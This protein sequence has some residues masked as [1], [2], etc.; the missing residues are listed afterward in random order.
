MNSPPGIHVQGS[1]EDDW[2]MF[3]ELRAANG[4]ADIGSSDDCGLDPDRGSMEDV[5]PGG[6]GGCSVGGGDGSMINT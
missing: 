5:M 1:F 4:K 3:N 2:K 6:L